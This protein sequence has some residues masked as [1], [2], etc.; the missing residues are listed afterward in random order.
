ML[1]RHVPHYT[2]TYVNMC[3]CVCVCA[4]MH[5]CMYVCMYVCIHKT[6]HGIFFL[7]LHFTSSWIHLDGE[8][9]LP[10]SVRVSQLIRQ[11]HQQMFF[12]SAR[13]LR[14]N[15]QGVLSFSIKSKTSIQTL[16]C[17]LQDCFIGK[18]AANGFQEIL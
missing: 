16:S 5:V 11:E 4:C 9:V 7:N 18:T 3:V 12:W 8:R 1:T 6:Y 15:H 14:L 17:S 10:N 2:T 13:L